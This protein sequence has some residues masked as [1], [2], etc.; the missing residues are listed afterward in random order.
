MTR[1][2]VLSILSTALAFGQTTLPPDQLRPGTIIGVMVC[3]PS[4]TTDGK[5]ILAA[6]DSSIVL[7]T[8]V[9][10]PVLRAVAAPPAA[11]WKTVNYPLTATQLTFQI[12]DP[13]YMVGSLAVYRNGIL[14]TQE[15]DYVMGGVSAA[16]TVVFVPKQAPVAGDIVVVKYAW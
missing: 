8:S 1:I 3:L 12:G 6:L 14:M 13:G 7:D 9:S 5:C 2:V 10:P 11:R 4:G 15:R 16:P